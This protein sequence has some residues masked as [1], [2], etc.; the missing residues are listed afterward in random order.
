MHQTRW[1]RRGA[2]AAGCL[3]LELVAAP[4]PA[5]P[6]D[7]WPGE[8]DPLPTSSDADELRAQWAELRALELVRA[9]VAFETPDPAE[10]QRLLNRAL[11]FDPGRESVHRELARLALVRVHRPDVVRGSPVGAGDTD[12][13]AT[14][15]RAIV[16]QTSGPPERPAG[17]TLARTDARLADLAAQVQAARFEVALETAARARRDVRGLPRQERL[18][19]AV[20]LEVL[21]ATAQLALGRDDDA[22]AS[23][24]RALEVDPGLEL[25]PRVTSPKVLRALEGARLASRGE[26]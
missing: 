11:C 9:A 7:P 15:D 24:E 14:L 12:A 25:D 20:R 21:T 23:L 19:R 6:C 22:R 5:R 8:P 10:A 1:T 2:I 26:P 17:A 18:P 16:L 13:W 4:A 3:L